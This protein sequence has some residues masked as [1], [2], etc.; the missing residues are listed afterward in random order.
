MLDPVF[1]YRRQSDKDRHYLR[2]R[3]EKNSKQI[4]PWGKKK[5]GVA[6]II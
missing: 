1:D 4:A 6:M 5:T 3:L 2:M